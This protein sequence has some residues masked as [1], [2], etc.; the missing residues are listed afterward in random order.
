MQN[1]DTNS[2]RDYQAT[3]NIANTEVA[4]VFC[5]CMAILYCSQTANTN[6][7]KDGNPRCKKRRQGERAG[8]M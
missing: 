8:Q 6:G 4:P 3:R 5:G 1:T 7:K 2:E